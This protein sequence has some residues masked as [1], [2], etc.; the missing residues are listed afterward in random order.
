[1]TNFTH[2]AVELISEAKTQRY[3]VTSRWD[4]TNLGVIKWFGR[5]RKYG[6]FPEPGTVFEEVCMRELSD[7]IVELT[8]RHRE[9]NKVLRGVKPASDQ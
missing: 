5:W 2:I 9:A 8:R 7:F 1:M 6:F 3:V 4:G